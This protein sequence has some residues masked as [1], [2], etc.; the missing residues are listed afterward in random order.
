MG[1]R[2]RADRQ[3]LQ[4]RPGPARQGSGRAPRERGGRRPLVRGLGKCREAAEVLPRPA[5]GPG[6]RAQPLGAVLRAGA[7][8]GE[9]AGPRRRSP[10]A[11]RRPPGAERR[12]AR[13]RDQAGDGPAARRFR[14]SCAADDHARLDQPRDHVRPDRDGPR[15]DGRVPHVPG[16]AGRRGLPRAGLPEHAPLARHPRQPRGRGP[17]PLRQQEPDRDD[18]VPGPGLHPHGPLGRARRS[19]IQLARPP[20]QASA[21]AS[22]PGT[23]PDASRRGPSSQG[24][25][26]RT[27][28]P[29]Y[30]PEPR[31]PS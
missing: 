12:A 17:L 29:S 31:D 15:P 2:R 19:P 26:S 10:R 24:P 1:G 30:S 20:A 4:V 14:A 22:A 7:G 9:A 27:Q 23:T 3:P 21:S 28:A 13:G 18:R 25:S 5:C 16:G 6:D 8:R 11:D